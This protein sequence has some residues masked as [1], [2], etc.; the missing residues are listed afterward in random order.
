[1]L[2]IRTSLTYGA[3]GKSHLTQTE[4]WNR[5]TTKKDIQVKDAGQVYLLTKSMIK[6]HILAWGLKG[7]GFFFLWNVSRNIWHFYFSLICL[8]SE[9]KK[10]H[11]TTLRV[12]RKPKKTQAREDIMLDNVSEEEHSQVFFFYFFF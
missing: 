7:C 1:M 2:S 11:C 12:L 4:P 8:F 9:L 5:H 3:L 10:P 6:L